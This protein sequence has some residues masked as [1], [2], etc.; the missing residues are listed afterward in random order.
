MVSDL[1]NSANYAPSE[2]KKENLSEIVKN[3]VLKA[4]DRIYLT[5]IKVEKEFDGIFYILADREKLEIA[6]LN[7][8]VNASEATVPGEGVI[9]I[10]ILDLE[11]DFMLC[12]SDNG[13]G[14]EEDQIQRLFEAFYSNKRMGVGVG[15]SSV[16]DIL[17]Q[18]DAQI[19]VKSNPGKGTSFQMLFPK[20]E[21]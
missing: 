6:L 12:I 8:L 14:I 3:A 13:H 10:E 15:L 9:K 20:W 1:L 19:K 21:A 4:S 11:H 16:K 17:E 2:L 7:L 5:G 18:H